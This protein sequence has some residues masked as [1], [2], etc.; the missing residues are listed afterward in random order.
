MCIG[1]F[2][3]QTFYH[4]NGS[5]IFSL[6]I[7]TVSW[8]ISHN[9]ATKLCFVVCIEFNRW[10]FH[11]TSE[12]RGHCQQTFPECKWSMID[13]MPQKLRQLL[14][15]IMFPNS[16]LYEVLALQRLCSGPA[17]RKSCFLVLSHNLCF[18][19]VQV[20]KKTNDWQSPFSRILV[21]NTLKLRKLSSREYKFLYSFLHFPCVLKL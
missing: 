6:V 12:N 19:Q 9:P 14:L 3:S 13:G 8:E 7:I 21:S 10:V 18:L 11:L 17:H 1:I 4:K 2:L 5:G 15:S 20:L 16:D